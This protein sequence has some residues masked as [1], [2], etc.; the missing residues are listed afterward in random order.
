[1]STLGGRVLLLCGSGLVV[2]LLLLSGETV[3]VHLASPSRE[4][5][6]FLTEEKGFSDKR[7][8][9]IRR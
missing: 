5:G 4:S 6:W 9:A 8:S 7:G 2:H 1:M 3:K